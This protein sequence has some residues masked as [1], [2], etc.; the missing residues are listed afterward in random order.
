MIQLNNPIFL[1][2]EYSRSFTLEYPICAKDKN[3]VLPYPTTDPDILRGELLH[4]TVV[5]TITTTNGI[6]KVGNNIENENS[7]EN[8]S[9]KKNKHL[10]NQKNIVKTIQ[11][12]HVRDKLLFYQGGHHGSCLP[13]R[14]ALTK[15]MNDKKVASK[16][17][18]R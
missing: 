10:S 4:T 11:T 16:N 17:R 8:N 18:R 15:L 9:K 5:S 6:Y 2:V 13:V 12:K 14:N 1:N 3:I 7:N